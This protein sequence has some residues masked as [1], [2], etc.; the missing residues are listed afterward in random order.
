MVDG[1]DRAIWGPAK[2]PAEVAKYR[3]SRGDAQTNQRIKET[4]VQNDYGALI[5]FRRHPRRLQDDDPITRP[6]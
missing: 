3:V 2:K 5:A 4:L 1:G 6:Q